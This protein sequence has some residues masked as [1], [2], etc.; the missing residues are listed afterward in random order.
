MTAA[1]HPRGTTVLESHDAAGD[2][3]ELVAFGAQLVE[4][5]TDEDLVEC[6]ACAAVVGRILPLMSAPLPPIAGCVG[7]C[8]CRLAPLSLE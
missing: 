8:R 2:L 6:L 7:T 5:L 3:A 1:R 4:L